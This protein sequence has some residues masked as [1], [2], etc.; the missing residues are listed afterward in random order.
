MSLRMWK[1]P[2]SLSYIKYV[3]AVGLQGSVPDFEHVYLGKQLTTK[4]SHAEQLDVDEN[5]FRI[6]YS[7][8]IENRKF[9]YETSSNSWFV[10][11]DTHLL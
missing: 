11:V 6:M 4:G 3:S 1:V 2:A 9:Y 8:I 10:L 5:R 7:F